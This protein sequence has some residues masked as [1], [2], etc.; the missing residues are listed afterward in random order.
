MVMPSMLLEAPVQ[1]PHHQGRK[2][3]HL[4]RPVKRKNLDKRLKKLDLWLGVD[5]MTAFAKRLPPLG[6]ELKG[7]LRE[8]SNDLK[9]EVT[10][11]AG[12]AWNAFRHRV[13]GEGHAPSDPAESVET[14]DKL[15]EPRAATMVVGRL[16]SGGRIDYVLQVLARA[17]PRLFVFPFFLTKV[18]G[19]GESTGSNQRALIFAAVTHLLLVSC[20]DLDLMRVF[21]PA[22]PDN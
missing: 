19:L 11:W 14:V 2:R 12:S 3:I 13:A 21:R 9:Q 20:L 16:N 7:Y 17:L 18:T 15:P 6:A 8:A 4:G 5:V 22:L 1:I 10:S